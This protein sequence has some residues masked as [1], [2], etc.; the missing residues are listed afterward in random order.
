M[1][2]NNYC[3]AEINILIL[4]QIFPSLDAFLDATYSV[5][6]HTIVGVHV[7]LGWQNE[8]SNSS[9]IPVFN[10]HSGRQVN[11]S[12]LDATHRVAFRTTVVGHDSR[13]TCTESAFSGLGCVATNRTRPVGANR[14]GEYDTRSM[15]TEAP[16]GQFKW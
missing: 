10:I 4:D 14:E 9:N 12:I 7:L 2:L 6:V 16:R 15:V 13:T 11:G 3:I 5:S 8:V 1:L